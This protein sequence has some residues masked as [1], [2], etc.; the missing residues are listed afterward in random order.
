VTT[1]LRPGYVRK[2][3][4]PYGAGATLTEYI[5]HLI[6]DDGT[7]YLA[8]TLMLEDSQYLTQPWV[9]TS[10]FKK[11]PDAKGWTPTPCSAR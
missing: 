7:R 9:R 3:G 2:N 5:A 6:D 10:Q 11:Q 1:H 8:A 4:V